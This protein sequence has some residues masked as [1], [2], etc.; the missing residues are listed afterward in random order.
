MP[1]R[2]MIDMKGKRYG[3]WLVLER[4]GVTGSGSITWKCVCDCGVER[5][6]IGQMLRNGRSTSCGC[7]TRLVNLKPFPKGTRWVVT[8]VVQAG[9]PS[10]STDEG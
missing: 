7:E 3:K 9:V 2:S 5:N 1:N 8:K 6:V 4:A 10:T